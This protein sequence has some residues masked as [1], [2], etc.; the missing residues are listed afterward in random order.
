MPTSLGRGRVTNNKSLGDSLAR[1]NCKRIYTSAVIFTQRIQA[2]SQSQ[3]IGLKPNKVSGWPRHMQA[4]FLAFNQQTSNNKF[5]T[6]FTM[7][8]SANSVKRSYVVFRTYMRLS[9]YPGCF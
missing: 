7:L 4:A 5:V 6:R 3:N 8:L 1:A 9:V 2:T